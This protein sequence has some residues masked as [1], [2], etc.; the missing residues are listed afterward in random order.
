MRTTRGVWSVF[1][2]ILSWQFG[3]CAGAD[4]L[5]CDQVTLSATSSTKWSVFCDAT[6]SDKL[7]FSPQRVQSFSVG[8]K[9][10]VTFKLSEPSQIYLSSTFHHIKPL[11]SPNLTIFSLSAEPG[12]I[13]TTAVTIDPMAFAKL[14]ALEVLIDSR[15]NQFSRIE[16]STSDEATLAKWM[17]DGT[18]Q[19]DNIRPAEDKCADGTLKQIQGLSQEFTVCVTLSSTVDSEAVFTES[20]P[21]DSSSDAVDGATSGSEDDDLATSTSGSSSSTSES[22]S[23][24]ESAGKDASGSL[25]SSTFT[26][27]ATKDET[28][29]QLKTLSP[30]GRTDES[31]T[32]TAD[33]HGKDDDASFP[34]VI[35]IALSCGTA[36]AVTI[37]YFLF[38]RRRLQERASEDGFD[39]PLRPLGS[40]TSIAT[41]DFSFA[42]R[43]NSVASMA[44]NSM[45]TPLPELRLSRDPSHGSRRASAP[46]TPLG[47]SFDAKYSGG[48]SDMSSPSEVSATAQRF[49]MSKSLQV[50]TGVTDFSFPEVGNS[51]EDRGT[52]RHKLQDALQ[53]ILNDGSNIEI[54]GKMYECYGT[55]D[56]TQYSFICK[57]RPE[58][59]AA[60]RL[61]LKLYAENDTIYA[62]REYQVLQSLQQDPATLSFVPQLADVQPRKT[63]KGVTC[64]ALLIEMGTST[65]FLHVVR[66]QMEKS[67]Q[68][69]VAHQLS[70]IVRALECLHSRH[71][72]H[73][74][75]NLESILIFDNDK[76][77]FR[78]LEHATKF[79]GD[80]HY[81]AVASVEF[82]PPE[83]ARHI[84]SDGCEGSD[85][86]SLSAAVPI[87]ASYSFDIWS[88]GIVILKMYSSSKHLDEFSGCG[89]PVDMLKRLADPN[90]NLERSIALYVPHEDVKDLVRQCLQREPSF[91][92]KIDAILRHPVLQAH[93][94]EMVLQ[95]AHSTIV[96]SQRSGLSSAKIRDE[97]T[98]CEPTPPS[99]WFFLPPKEIGLDRCLSID[100]WVVEMEL[101]L[102]KKDSRESE[103]AFPLLFMCE[104]STGLN[105]PCDSTGP[106]RSRL[107]VP[108]SLISLVMP[109]VQET[110][111][112]L[113]TKAILSGDSALHIAQVSGLGQ[114]QWSELMNFYRALEKMQMAPVSSFTLMM[115]KP[116]E[117][118]LANG[119][120]TNAQQ[121]LDEVKYLAF[122]Q[123]KRDH[124]QSLLEIIATSNAADTA[125]AM[126]T[127]SQE[128]S[129]LRKCHV[130]LDDTS[131]NLCGTRWL[132]RGH[133][134]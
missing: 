119:D 101:L 43:R 128:W 127:S 99:L 47:G 70:R 134:P 40:L 102:Q 66:G 115:L 18:L 69:S 112:F 95:L 131:V 15:L 90:F 1:C 46:A 53:D 92:P 25:K 96:G 79:N 5:L 21:T 85:G 75:L 78:D 22:N 124:V 28:R 62:A 82:L 35:A 88:L 121:V 56:E 4:D 52:T 41:E 42:E 9:E 97:K 48:Y 114:R 133:L 129:G 118:M 50:L 111:L 24:N 108:L 109:L 30:Q 117:E 29:S 65:T 6:A 63:L 55:L 20:G 107:S 38:R 120:R 126:A 73:G 57:C 19:I 122:T 23:T 51:V 58:D 3:Q 94:H 31:T 113:E 54:N 27:A 59:D 87:A 26:T 8:H 123:E 125:A 81:C 7:V 32:T 86:S 76:L 71:F 37:G 16:A 132:C 89:K 61:W 83:I 105:R 39:K 34:V 103:L 49:V 11:I 91:R 130:E 67:S 33:N 45:I 68:S 116:L 72:I 2:A 84:L 74:S 13:H 106:Y 93:E 98:G 104:A 64:S 77:K 17:K 80:V 100:E 60:T 36:V 12:W 10:S 44:S 14:S 110:T